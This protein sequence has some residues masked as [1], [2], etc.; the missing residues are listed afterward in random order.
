MI[1]S[2]KQEKYR[3]LS[4]VS[5]VTGIFACGSLITFPGNFNTFSYSFIYN[6][7]PET[8]IYFILSFY[9]I[10]LSIPAIVCG[11]IDLKKIRAGLSSNKG[12][13]LDLAGVLL[14][15]VFTLFTCFIML[16]YF[17]FSAD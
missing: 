16:L 4:I 6:F 11:S 8:Y 10:F 9:V 12:F 7:F 14:G 13:G 17:A 3:G 1:N 2:I 5:L 15:S